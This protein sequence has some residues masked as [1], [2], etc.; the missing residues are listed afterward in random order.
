M[1]RSWALLE[2]QAVHGFSRRDCIEGIGLA[3]WAYEL[4]I[5][6]D[7]LPE[8]LADELRILRPP[9]TNLSLLLLL[10]GRPDMQARLVDDLRAGRVSDW[11]IDG[12]E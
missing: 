6:L 7:D 12:L 8:Q 1:D 11:I 5:G 10:E 4:M 2:L 9:L 3:D